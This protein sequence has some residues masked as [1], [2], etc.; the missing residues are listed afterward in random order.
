ML[1]VGE[2]AMRFQEIYLFIR[3]KT[4]SRLVNAD[5][6]ITATLQAATTLGTMATKILVLAT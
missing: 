4:Y 2:L 5:W 3:A 6:L 1:K